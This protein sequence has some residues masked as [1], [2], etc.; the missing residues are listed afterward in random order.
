ML[1]IEF[2]AES[3]QHPRVVIDPS[4]KKISRMI[5]KAPYHE[6]RAI[7]H[8]GHIYVWNSADAIHREVANQIGV[9]YVVNERMYFYNS[10][11][12]PIISCNISVMEDMLERF[13]DD[14]V[15]L[16]NSG[17]DGTVTAAE[18]LALLSV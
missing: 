14:P 15:V 1:L 17:S 4:G 13:A 9:P 2:I 3:S 11:V 16:F 6:L 10:P 8:D 18:F 5:D 7:A 12:G